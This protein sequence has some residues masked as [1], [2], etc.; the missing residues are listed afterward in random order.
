[1]K[2]LEEYKYFETANGI[3]YHGDCLEIMPLLENKS[4]NVSFTSPPYN[5]KRN[6][7][8]KFYD[9]NITDYY[10]FLV[11]VLNELKR[12]TSRNIF[13]NIQKTM[14]NKKDVFKII[15]EFYNDIYEIF[16]W[17]KSNPL[18]ANG[19]NITNAYEFII[20]FGEWLKSNKTY[21]K[22]HITTSV[23][24]M[25]KEHKAVMNDKISDFFM[26]NFT[27]NEDT[28]LDCFGGTG[29]TAISCIKNNRKFVLI[30]KHEEYCEIAKKRI[31]AEYNQI[32][33]F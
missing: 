23:T 30:E 28:I 24:V 33:M 19:L 2:T 10:K 18:P 14:Y 26:E 3:L 29:T 20:C 5:R 7:K 11:D 12:I 13:F 32:K 4:V 6:D 15:G 17:E 25:P 21:T 8:Y 9:D 27:Q 1:M 31:L 16:I 22:N